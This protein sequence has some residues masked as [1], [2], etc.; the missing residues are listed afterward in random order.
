MSQK[1]KTN[2]VIVHKDKK[3][4]TAQ[5]NGQ[6][7]KMTFEELSLMK[8]LINAVLNDYSGKSYASY[9]DENGKIILI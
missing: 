1:E 7:I 4:F 2:A 3:S 6:K 5:I 9:T 8:E